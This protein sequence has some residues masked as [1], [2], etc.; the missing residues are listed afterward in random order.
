MKRENSNKASTYTHTQNTLTQIIIITKQKCEKKV[1][2][3]HLSRIIILLI[4]ILSYFFL[5]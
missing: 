3:G 2:I 4:T 1:S 5:L